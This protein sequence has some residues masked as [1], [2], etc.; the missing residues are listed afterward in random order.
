MSIEL[1]KQKFFT[2]FIHR[3]TRVASACQLFSQWCH[4]EG[5]IPESGLDFQEVTTFD[6]FN[7]LAPDIDAQ[8]GGNQRGKALC[9]VRFYDLW[10]KRMQH[11]KVCWLNFI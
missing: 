8:T 9:C 7:A 3:L 6:V 11:V 4:R 2:G 10:K 1:Y 5:Q